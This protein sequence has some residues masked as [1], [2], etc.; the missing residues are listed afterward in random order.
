M[1]PVKVEV[2]YRSKWYQLEF[3]YTPSGSISAIHLVRR[4]LR[5]I[6]LHKPLQ[7]MT[8]PENGDQQSEIFF[9]LSL[10]DTKP[11][12]C[13]PAYYSFGSPFKAQAMEKKECRNFDNA[14]PNNQGSIWLP[15][16]TSNHKSFWVTGHMCKTALTRLLGKL[17]RDV[18]SLHMWSIALLQSM[19]YIYFKY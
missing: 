11:W 3:N 19:G 16:A 14:S 7:L 18:L 12:V 2:Q 6:Q 5:G 9:C 8:K 17:L 15:M 13:P 10:E 1:V 4:H